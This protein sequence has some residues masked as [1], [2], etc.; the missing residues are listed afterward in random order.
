MIR[1]FLDSS[2]LFA[3]IISPNGAARVLLLLGGTGQIG[4][5]VSEQV[6]AE[7][8]RAVARKVP[9]A[10]NELRQAKAWIDHL[11]AAIVEGIVTLDDK[12]HVTFLSPGAEHICGL[13]QEQVLGQHCDSVFHLVDDAL[14]SQHLPPPGGRSSASRRRSSIRWCWDSTSRRPASTTAGCGCPSSP[15]CCTPAASCTAGRSRR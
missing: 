13:Q 2:A 12:N 5:L 1:L 14:F 15:S 11:L 4:L 9:R 3:G 6:I 7:T 8:E 10:L